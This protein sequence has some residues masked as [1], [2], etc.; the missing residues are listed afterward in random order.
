MFKYL[1]ECD[2]F[3]V[4]CFFAFSI[5][6]VSEIIV[7][8]TMYPFLNYTEQPLIEFV[9]SS[10]NIDIVNKMPCANCFKV[11]WFGR[12]P[13]AQTLLQSLATSRIKYKREFISSYDGVNL[14]LDYKDDLSSSDTTTPIVLCLHGLGGDSGSRFIETFTNLSMEHGYRTIVYNRRGHGTSLLSENR[15]EEI[16][17]PRHVNMEDMLVVVDHLN[18]KYPDAIKFLIGFSAGANL[19]INYI[20][21]NQVDNPFTATISISNGYDI[22]KGTELL[23]KKTVCDG[24]VSQFLKD[25]LSKQRIEEVGKIAKKLN[26]SIDLNKVLNCKS[27]RELEEM[28]VVPSYKLK[29]LQEYYE[30]DSCHNCIMSVSSPLLCISNKNDPLVDKS[31]C[32]IPSNAANTNENIISII[33]EHGGHV[34]WIDNSLNNPW[35]SRVVFEYMDVI[36]HHTKVKFTKTIVNT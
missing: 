13:M 23:A 33:T 5:M 21:K 25:I 11:A 19:A 12:G 16:I 9:K 34:G 24:I 15:E 14:A 8:A 28:L 27:V 6:A 36:R 7:S 1:S 20:A 32:E 31:M 17:F 18:K 29:S 35:Y 30:M 22:Y 10:K 26:I 3:G 4:L 2:L